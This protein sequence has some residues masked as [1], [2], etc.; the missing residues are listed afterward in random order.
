MNVQNL[1]YFVKRFHKVTIM[2]RFGFIIYILTIY[3]GENMSKELGKKLSMLRNNSELTQKNIADALHLDRSTYAYYER[4][5]TE[6]DL[7]ALVKIARILNVDP[8]EL[9][10]SRD[11]EETDVADVIAEKKTKGR[12]GSKTDPRSKNSKIYSLSPDE[13][14]LLAMYRTL[15]EDNRQKVV[16]FTDTLTVEDNK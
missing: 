11:S 1:S 2:S 15:D 10:P 9:L 6:P 13:K 7:K 8:S 14:R 12:K 16:E 5:T 3:R 4:G